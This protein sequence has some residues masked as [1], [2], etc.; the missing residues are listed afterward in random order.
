M[1]CDS[2]VMRA[3]PK[4]PERPLSECTARKA[5]FT[6]V[7]SRP[8]PYN[9]IELSKELRGTRSPELSPDGKLLAAL[10]T[11]GNKLVTCEVQENPPAMRL[12]K[13]LGFEI[14]GTHR[15]YAFRDGAYVDAHTMARVR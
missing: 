7:A 2:A 14:E 6:R 10:Q 13:K 4:R 11:D 12:Y 9:A 8:A 3:M 15:K 1:L 5:S